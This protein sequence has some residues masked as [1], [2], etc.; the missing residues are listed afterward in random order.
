MKRLLSLIFI[1]CFIIFCFAGCGNSK[2]NPSMQTIYY[3]LKSEP[4]SLDPQIANDESSQLI[5]SNIFEGLVKIDSNNDILPAV[6]KNYESN[7][8]FTSFTFH[9]RDDAKWSD[10]N[11]TP[12]TADDFVF[13]LKRAISPRT[14]SSTAYNLLPIKNAKE[15]NSGSL[16]ESSL[17]VYAIDPYTLKID[18]EYSYEQFP[19]LM[20]LP[21]A[22]PCNQRLFDNTNGQYGLQ[23]DYVISNGPFMLKDKQKES[24]ILV[25]NENY[26]GNYEAIPISVNF[27]IGSLSGSVFDNIE[28]GK[29]DA[30]PIDTS[31]ISSAEKR[32][33]NITS[34]EDTTWGLTFNLDSSIFKNLN[35]RKA[36]VQSLNRDYVLSTI[37]SNSSIANDIIMSSIMFEGNRYRNLAGDNLYLQK[38][39]DAKSILN[40]GKSE[41]GLK[42]LP[43]ITV[44]CPEDSA[45]KSLVSNMIEIWNK[46]LD[47]YFN[48]EPVSDDKLKE[49]LNSGNY[50]IAVAPIQ[51][52]DNDPLDIL[53]KFTSDSMY[54][55]FNMDDS[56]YDSIISKATDANSTERLNLCI[57]AEKYIN[58]QAVFYPLYCNKRF[59]GSSP[60]VKN[61][62]FY[63]YGGVVDFTKTTKGRK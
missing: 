22:M 11:S 2:K 14:K 60:N 30:G 31:D 44:L 35:I 25:K 51:V 13:A 59:F 42:S 61:I 9:L 16:K 10:K 41:L 34:F 29:I 19:R 4:A 62:I 53:S 63:Q 55:V 54:N 1:I 39:S 57:Q 17:G 21:V 36:F 38:S 28:K 5:I 3:N 33:Y 37:P 23:A 43:S 58:N 27:T 47:D 26:R 24:L 20:A 48:M 50:Q 49:K 32:K 45:V 46:E 15:I 56:N 6:S 7:D 40:S 8:N 12:V 52:T 18:L